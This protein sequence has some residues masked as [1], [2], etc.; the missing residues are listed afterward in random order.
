MADPNE[1]RPFDWRDL[2]LLHRVRD[3]GLCLTSRLAYT[4][5]PHALQHAL[6]DVINPGRT[7]VTL[8]ARAGAGVDLSSVGQISLTDEDPQAHVTFVSPAEIFEQSRAIRLLEALA[9]AAGER[10][11]HNLIAEAD[12]D[13]QAFISLRRAGFAIYA[14]QRIWRLGEATTLPEDR[15][16]GAW[17]AERPA[18]EAAV[19][20]LYTDLVPA[21]VQQVEAEPRSDGHGLVHWH[22]NE[23]LG[24]LH[25][26]RGPLGI[27][28]QPY[29]HPAAEKLDRLLASYLV[30]FAAG[31]S[32][33][34][35]LCVRSYQ[36]SVN[37]TL[38]SL[39]F[40]PYR[41]QAVMVKRL[42]AA[43]RQSALAR[44]PQ[45]EGTRPEPTAPFMKVERANAVREAGR[46][47]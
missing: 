38:Q 39:G 45:L 30:E 11:A 34:W 33:P 1:I 24:Y 18:D 31:E 7:T 43:V 4:R 44:L 8:V 9:H 2:T 13:S 41:D 12:E 6:L 36:G 15:E 28:I 42:A 27:W 23:L 5:G 3:R 17:R 26:E 20:G 14:R 47:S 19:Q 40:E 25:I 35:H 16:P 46:E 21:L 32:R 10:G 37:A 22:E 29:F